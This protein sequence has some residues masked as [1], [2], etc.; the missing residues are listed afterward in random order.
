MTFDLYIWCLL[1]AVHN[2][3]TAAIISLWRG[4]EQ[5]ILVHPQSSLQTVGD[6]AL[7][8]VRVYTKY[9]YL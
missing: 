9:W 5:P 2:G 8:G 1:C 4:R 6:I 3:Q 7:L